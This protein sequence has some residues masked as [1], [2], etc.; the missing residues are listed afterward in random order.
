MLFISLHYSIS[1]YLWSFS[2]RLSSE[3]RPAFLSPFVLYCPSFSTLQP[4]R[5]ILFS[6][7]SFS[8]IYFLS[9]FSVIRTSNVA[10]STVD[11]PQSFGSPAHFAREA[12]LSSLSFLFSTDKFIPA[13]PVPSA[14]SLESASAAGTTTFDSAEQP[15]EFSGPQTFPS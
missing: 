3:R 10:G 1:S 9:V 8:F 14:A 12:N 7:S 15:L 5:R 13:A 11:L 6:P 2:A 4:T